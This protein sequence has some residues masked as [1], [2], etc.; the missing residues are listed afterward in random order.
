VSSLA[1]LFLSMFV[2]VFFYWNIV[3]FLLLMPL[4]GGWMRRRWVLNLHLVYGI[5]VAFVGVVNFSLIPIGNLMGRYDWTISSTFGW[6]A[7]AARIE[8]LEQTHD[9]GFVAA[10]RYTTAAQLGFAMHNADVTAIAA[11]HDQ[12]D[13]WCRTHGSASRT[14]RGPLTA[15]NCW[16]PCHSSASEGSFM[17]RGSISPPASTLRLRTNSTAESVA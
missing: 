13:W 8:A 10:T 11:R 5:V 4:L 7:V 12:Y 2:E 14:F 6:P 1:M 17:R 3:A 16:K 15:S 9:V